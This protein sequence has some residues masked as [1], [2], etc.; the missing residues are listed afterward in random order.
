MTWTVLKA[1]L[2]PNQ[3]AV[4]WQDRQTDGQTPDHYIM[5]SAVEAASKTKGEGNTVISTDGCRRRLWLNRLP[6]CPDN[7]TRKRQSLSETQRRSRYGC[8]CR[9]ENCARRNWLS[10]GGH[11]VGNSN[12]NRVLS[13]RATIVFDPLPRRSRYVCTAIRPVHVTVL[14]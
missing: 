7:S 10:G 5:L 2:N 13:T 6:D 8:G 11:A 12:H 3:P 14:Y 4:C 1:P 9:R